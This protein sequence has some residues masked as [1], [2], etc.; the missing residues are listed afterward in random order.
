[1]TLYIGTC[2]WEYAHWRGR[3]Y[4]GT[5]GREDEL[6]YYAARFGSVEVDGTF[7]RLP[8]AEVFEDWARR[9]PDDFVFS[10]KASRYLT[11]IRRLKEPVEPVAH[12][13]SRVRRLGKKLGPI[14]LQLPPDMR[15]DAGR[16]RDALRAFGPHTRVAVE[17]RHDS[18]YVEE[19]RATLV[20]HEAA[21]CLA[22][23]G[24]RLVTPTWRTAA[25][26]Y[27]RFHYGTGRPAG[28]YGRRALA[29]RAETIRRLFGPDADVFA[30]FNNDGYA[31]ALRD[32]RT[33]AGAARRQ[34][35]RPARVPGLRDVRAG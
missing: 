21:L 34:G 9:V 20:A 28:C 15:R 25:W 33:F 6:A 11:H 31:C 14:L 18:W 10:I 4:P 7:Y 29:A 13:L 24:S 16:L 5:R 1:V 19:T 35:L 23:R 12:L 32:A 2:G 17:F 3:F 27:M 22:D 8:E 26:G 30:Y